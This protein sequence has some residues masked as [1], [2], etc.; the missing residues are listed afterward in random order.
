MTQSDPASVIT[1][2]TMVKINAIIVQPPSA[3]G[4]HVQEVDHVHDDL[5][6]GAAP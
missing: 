4:V 1:T 5:D 3:L 6:H 2:M